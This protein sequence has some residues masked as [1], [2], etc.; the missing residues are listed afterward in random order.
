MLDI[1]ADLPLHINALGYLTEKLETFP[2][3]FLRAFIPWSRAHGIVLVEDQV[4]IIAQEIRVMLPV[5]HGSIA[6]LG[7]EVA[8]LILALIGTSLITQTPASVGTELD[9]I[10]FAMKA[11]SPDR[12][13]APPDANERGSKHHDDEEMSDF[14]VGHENRMSLS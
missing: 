10:C 1:D 8:Q 6:T 2:L 13:E 7:L 9:T 5:S 11:D 12:A 14:F 3:F 4:C